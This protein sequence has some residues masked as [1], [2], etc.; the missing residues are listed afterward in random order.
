[1]RKVSGKICRENPNTLISNNSFLFENL[2]IYE[3]MWE[4]IIA[5]YRTQMTLWLMH[6][7]CWKTKGTDTHSEHY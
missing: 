4:I 1:M 3:I 7:A 2:A 5:P 6:I